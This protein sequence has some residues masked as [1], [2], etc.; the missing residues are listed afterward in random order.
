[1]S[2]VLGE[3][4]IR[5]WR[6][7]TRAGACLWTGRLCAELYLGLHCGQWGLIAS[8]LSSRR[9]NVQ[10][11]PEAE[12]S[13]GWEKLFWGPKRPCLWVGRMWPRLGGLPAWSLVLYKPLNCPWRL[14]EET[15]DHSWPALCLLRLGVTWG[16][17]RLST[18]LGLCRT[19]FWSLFCPWGSVWEL[20]LWPVRIWRCFLGLLDETFTFG[21][22]HWSGGGGVVPLENL[23]QQMW[24]GSQESV[25]YFGVLQGGGF[26]LSIIASSCLPEG[27]AGWN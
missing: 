6:W 17:G 26:H 25:F 13:L 9:L 14:K 16:G 7:H 3:G 20:L 27:S 19:D 5:M 2:S 21:G 4:E 24:A 10:Q 18:T 12:L 11:F 1:M 22:W 15:N 8:A 23:I